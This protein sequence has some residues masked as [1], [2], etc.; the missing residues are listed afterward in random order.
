[1]P[2]FFLPPLLCG[3]EVCPEGALCPESF[4]VQHWWP[5]G[6]EPLAPQGSFSCLGITNCEW[7]VVGMGVCCGVLIVFDCTLYNQG[8]FGK[9][10]T[11]CFCCCKSPGPKYKECLVKML[12][13]RKERREKKK[14]LYPYDSNAVDVYR[15][16]EVLKDNRLFLIE[17]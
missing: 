17:L 5:G 7:G 1:M 16:A 4:S 10:H 3:S 11:S 13:R 6:A 2:G 14:L 9:R 8:V 12:R 15:V